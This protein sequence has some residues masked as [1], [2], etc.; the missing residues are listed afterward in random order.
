MALAMQRMIVAPL[1][2]L[3]GALAGLASAIAGIELYAATPAAPGSPWQTW[4]SGTGQGQPY[5]LGHYLLSGRF[6]PAAG[7]M[8]EFSSRSADDGSALNAA[9]DYVL[10][11]KSPPPLWWS[12][13]T[14]AGSRAGGQSNAVITADTAIAESDG[15]MRLNVSRLPSGGNWIRPVASGSF[16]LIFTVAEPSPNSPH[17]ATPLFSIERGAC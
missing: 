17:Q 5:A 10:A 4:D 12:M 1:I 6:P 13:A 16:A 7:Q 2:L 3:A 14:F 8:R 11:S 15:S 9:C